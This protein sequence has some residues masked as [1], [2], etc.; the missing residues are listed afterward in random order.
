MT[1]MRIDIVKGPALP[2][3]R[4]DCAERSRL[5]TAVQAAAIREAEEIVDAARREADRL[6]AGARAAVCRIAVDAR[7]E[8]SREGSRHWNE[9]AIALAQARDAS[10][11]SVEREA[12]ALALEIA[13][14]IVGDHVAS[15]PGAW[16]ELIARSTER[17]RRDATLVIRH[18]PV[19][20]ERVHVVRD[21]L[22]AF[23]E[24]AFEPDDSLDAGDCIAECAGV[25]VD[26]RID[27]QL[28]A[29]ERLLV[30]AAQSEERS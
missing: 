19:D 24:V 5:L 25:R 26:A 20:S 14:R 23:R 9:S 30:D 1:I 13:R 16:A 2:L 18:A 17:L 15:S 29:V 12:V 6:V 8:A 28:A 3:R 21:R 10:I 7:A 11:A 22:K 27:V 4:I